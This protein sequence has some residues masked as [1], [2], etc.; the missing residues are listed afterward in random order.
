M[1]CVRYEWTN[2]RENV[3]HFTTKQILF[4]LLHCEYDLTRTEAN[5][6][7]VYKVDVIIDNY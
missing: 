5:D 7:T 2:T 3:S 1:S 6:V 4:Y